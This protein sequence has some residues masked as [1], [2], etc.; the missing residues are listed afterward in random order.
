MLLAL[1]ISGALLLAQASPSVESVRQELK[2]RLS[3][4]EKRPD[5]TPEMLRAIALLSLDSTLRS[6]NFD[7]WV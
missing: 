5:K 4:F 3:D 7:V 6:T 2:Q 1:S